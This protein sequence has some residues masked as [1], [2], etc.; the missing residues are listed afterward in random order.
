MFFKK[1]KVVTLASPLTG[2]SVGLDEVP[3]PTFAQ[4]FIGD[5][6]AIK[7]TEGLLV[8]PCDGTVAYLI[9]TYH[10]A[11]IMHDSGIEVLMH[12]GVNTVQLKGEGFKPH[13]KTGDRVKQGQLLIQFDIQAIEGA[14]YPTITPVIIANAELVSKLSRSF[15]YVAPGAGTIMEVKM[16]S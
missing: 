10:S 11:I 2:T 13:V 7:P 16:K 12:I 14:G 3:D 8:S 15:G 1:K 6:I 5:G 4:G 9:D